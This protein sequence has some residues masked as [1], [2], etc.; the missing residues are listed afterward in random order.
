MWADGVDDNYHVFRHQR[1]LSWHFK[2]N[3]HNL[4]VMTSKDKQVFAI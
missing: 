4:A 1:A 3:L 2:A